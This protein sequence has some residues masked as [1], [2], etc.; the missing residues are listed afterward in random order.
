[1]ADTLVSALIAIYWFRVPFRGSY[2]TLLGSSAMFMV[3]VLSMGFFISVLAKGQFAASQIALLV[4]FLPAFLLSGFLF[5]IE[6]MPIAL[7]WI[8]RIV[9]A[10]Y[11][12][13]VLKKIFLKGTPTALLY[14]DLIPLALFALVLAVLATRSFHKRLT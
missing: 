5:S 2:L 9:P 4:T 8:T 14:A 10:R 12:M 13:S 3:V 6:Q 1:M 11:Y 7:Q